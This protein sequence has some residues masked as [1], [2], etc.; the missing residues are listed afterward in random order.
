MKNSILIAL[1]AAVLGTSAYA[2]GNDSILS[3]RAAPNDVVVFERDKGVYGAS[4]IA[5][6][7]GV[8]S[9]VDA[10]RILLPREQAIATNGKVVVY[11][12]NTKA[13]GADVGKSFPR[14]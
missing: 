1:A 8:A 12:F 3:S 6:N 10:S 14:R 4:S 9:L 2:G 13:P 11:S 5:V 7:S